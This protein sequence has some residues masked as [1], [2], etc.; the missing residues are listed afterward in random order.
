MI[1]FFRKI[2]QNLLTENKFSKYLLYAIGEIVLVIIGILIA[3]TLNNNNE[4]KKTEIKTLLVFDELLEDLA[5]DITSIKNAG[6]F[7]EEKDSLT[8]LVLNTELT[9]E[10]YQNG[11]NQYLALTSATKTINLSDNA[12]KK[13]IQ[14]SEDIPD[15]FSEIMK[16]LYILNQKKIYVDLIGNEMSKY[17]RDINHYRI[18]NYTWAINLNNQ[19]EIVNYFL[20]D[21]RYKS[22]VT[23]LMNSGVDEHFE[24]AVNYLDRAI[25]CYKKIATL[26]NKPMDYT[27]FGYNPDLSRKII[28]T[29]QSEQ[30]PDLIVTVF[31]DD[32]R[33]LYKNNINSSIGEFYA[34]SKTKLFGSPAVF[35]TVSNEEKETV[36]YSSGDVWKKTKG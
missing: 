22:D 33:L 18:Y 32:N 10:D 36:F 1:K 30:V 20:N 19:E 28:G 2:R 5:S 6:L 12:Y 35:L 26:R 14:I 4:R 15:A 31:E 29:W 9:R 16:E 7:Y 25:S 17:V 8:H 11:F 27:L 24:H 13:L 3:L 23:L 21:N 34:L